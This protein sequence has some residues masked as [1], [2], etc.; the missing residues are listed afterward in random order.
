MRPT[1]PDRMDLAVATTQP[2]AGPAGPAPADPPHGGPDMR[3]RRLGRSLP[4]AL[5]LIL[6]FGG[7]AAALRG[8]WEQ[9]RQYEWQFEPWAVGMSFAVM[10]A[11]SVWAA[12]SWL[13]VARAFGA[14]LPTWPALRIYSTSNLGKYL[15]GKVL[16]AFARVYLAQQQGVPLALATTTVVIDIVL[17]IASATLFMVLALPTIVGDA[18]GVDASLLAA[19]AVVGVVVGLGLLHP[20]ALNRGFAVARRL[21]PRRSFPPIEVGYGTIL[22]I[23]VLY[24]IIWALNTGGLFFAVQAVGEVGVADLPKL[25][26]VYALSY[27]AGLFMPL[28][29]GGLGVREGLMTALLSQLIPLPAAAAASVLV[30]VVQVAAEGLCAAVFSRG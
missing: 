7:L 28:A 27:L 10:V 6:L 21:M 1:R 29:P 11:G 25:G 23:F 26:A 3:H 20:A 19:V 8:G 22:R 12:V 15:P 18:T 30:R 9:L 2:A 13:L 14:R 16:H 17:Y 5:V 24:V 4:R